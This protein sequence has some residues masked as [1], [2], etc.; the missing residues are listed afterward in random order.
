MK[1]KLTTNHRVAL[2]RRVAILGLALLLLL[3]LIAS[4][5]GQAGAAAAAAPTTLVF[6]DNVSPDAAYQGVADTYLSLYEPN[7]A[8]GTAAT[9]RINPNVGG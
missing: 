8:Y 1:D 5:T 2:W 4:A 7:T 3:S 6:Q 9:M